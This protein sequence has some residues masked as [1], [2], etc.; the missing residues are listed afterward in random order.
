MTR[1]WSFTVDHYLLL[2]LG[3]AIAI[4]WANTHPVSYFS[5]TNALAFPVNTIG[6]AFVLAYVAQEVTEAA[7]PGGTLRRRN[8]AVPMVA[9]VGA[10]L[11]AIAVYEAYIHSGDGDVLAQGWPIVC[12]VD[13]LLA[14]AIGRFIFRRTAAQTVVVVVAIGSDII[15]LAVISTRTLVPRGHPAA[16]L[17]I[18]TAVMAS[19]ALHRA[20]WR[21]VWPYV[22][23]SGVLSWLGCYWAGVHPALALLPIVPFFA[24]TP[25]DLNSHRGRTPHAAHDTSGH[26]EHLFEYPVQAI[27]FAVGLVNAGVV[28]RGFGTGTWAVL[29]ASLVARPVGM[30]AAVAIAVAAGL[31]LPRGVGWREMLVV[32]FAASPSF[33]FGVFFAAS[34]F[35]GGPLLTETKMGAM[36]TAAG[37]LLALAVARVLR[38]GRFAHSGERPRIE[39]RLIRRPA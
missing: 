38:A 2:P 10:T 15:G 35:P 8:S 30:L 14:R 11:G 31:E 23:S 32:A 24:H 28:I 12:A 27:A 33:G 20:G 4:A 6:M 29:T 21:S 13:V 39:P 19:A 25:R 3:A 1:A 17:L 26:F 9:A 18:V 37:V 36:G 34:V 16:A 5:A 22:C 7:L